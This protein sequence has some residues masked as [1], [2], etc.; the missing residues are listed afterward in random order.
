MRLMPRV[1]IYVVKYMLQ[2]VKLV[3]CSHVITMKLKAQIM[4][5]E[6]QDSMFAFLRLVLF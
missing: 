4:D 5:M 3:R 2:E 6:P 1:G